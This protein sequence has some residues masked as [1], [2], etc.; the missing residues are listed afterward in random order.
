[1]E[2]DAVML[3]PRRA[4]CIANGF[5]HD[6]TINDD[7]TVCVEKFPEKIALTA[8]KTESGEITRFTYRELATMADRIAIG[9]RAWG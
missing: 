3:L 1:M 5:W 7:L 4:A 8:I 6:R 9:Y 2:F